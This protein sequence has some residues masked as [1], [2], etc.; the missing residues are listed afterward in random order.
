L[1]GDSHAADV[2]LAD[3]HLAGGVPQQTIF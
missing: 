3:D 2:I 1:V